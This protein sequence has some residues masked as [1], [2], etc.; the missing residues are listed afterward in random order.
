VCGGREISAVQNVFVF[1]PIPESGAGLWHDLLDRPGDEL[2]SMPAR[3]H[4]R[5][6]QR[7]WARALARRLAS[8][9]VR[10][11]QVSA[12]SVVIAA[13][14]GVLLALSLEPGGE[15]CGPFLLAAAA[16][17]QLRLLCNM[18]DGLLAVEG[19]L[20]TPDGEM[21]NDLPDRI[22]DPLV[23][24]GAGLAVRAL[25]AGLTLG[26]LAAVLALMTAY[27]RVLGGSMGVPQS[28]A[29]PMAKQHRMF[30]ITVG[31]V[32]SAVES[33]LGRP[34]RTLYL[35]LAVV[36]VGAA[37]TLVRRATRI[38]QELRRR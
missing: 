7:G 37:V 22:A 33:A 6:R 30:A 2:M 4:L 24:V 13:A 21:W 28:F 36:V 9:G 19:R 26:W 27:V 35:S 20:A 29:G 3:R 18:I 12:A 15:T 8:A 32:A 38:A 17:V 25:P 31:C 1:P 34:P 11:N 10:P 5:T 23:L 16:C 14:A